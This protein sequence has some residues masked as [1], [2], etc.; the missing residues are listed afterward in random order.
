MS[1]IFGR[2]TSILGN[3]EVFAATIRKARIIRA[4]AGKTTNQA[5]CHIYGDQP[6]KE[7][8]AKTIVQSVA[9]N[10]LAEFIVSHCATK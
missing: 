10:H 4:L 8:T 1:A 6:S 5:N 9:W 2:T 7:R 3:K